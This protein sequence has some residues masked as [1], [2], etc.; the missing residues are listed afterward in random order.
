MIPNFLVSTYPVIEERAIMSNGN[1]GTSKAEEFRQESQ[2]GEGCAGYIIVIRH[3]H[4]ILKD[5]E[6]AFLK[7]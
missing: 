5:I 3:R 2:A 4:A 7:K 6:K 1:Q